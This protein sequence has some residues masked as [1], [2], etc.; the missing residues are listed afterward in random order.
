MSGD[1]TLAVTLAPEQLDA[2]AERVA[3]IL[4]ERQATA[5][6]AGDYIT[7]TVAAGML[8]VSAKTIRNM[9]SDGRLTRH[10]APRRP[11]VAR[12]EVL[13]LARGEGRQPRENVRRPSARPRRSARTFTARARGV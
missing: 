9:V 1:L 8:G 10:G 12:D 2:L 7:P 3:D 5:E 4:A 13:A 6:V 11:L